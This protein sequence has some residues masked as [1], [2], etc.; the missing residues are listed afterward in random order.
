MRRA[1]AWEKFAAQFMAVR[2]QAE[3]I[4]RIIISKFYHNKAVLT[5]FYRSGRARGFIR[6]E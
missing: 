1:L 6:Q 4:S 5:N 3:H 2:G